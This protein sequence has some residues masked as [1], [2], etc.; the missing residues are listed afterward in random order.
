MALEFGPGEP[1]TEAPEE[2]PAAADDDEPA[3]RH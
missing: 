2:A 3:E 1:E